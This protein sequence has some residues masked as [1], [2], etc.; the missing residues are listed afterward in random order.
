MDPGQLSLSR[1]TAVFVAGITLVYPPATPSFWARA[2]ATGIHVEIQLS[3]NSKNGYVYILASRRNG[4]MYVSV[5]SDLVKRTWQHKN[6]MMEGFTNKYRVHRLV[7]YEVFEDMT[8]A[9]AR[10]KELKRFRRA[11]KIE[12][13]ERDNADWNDLYSEITA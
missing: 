3:V 10:E 11:Q 9:I 5:T 12:L 13:I 2:Y 8:N 1:V 4:T 7:Y 6:E